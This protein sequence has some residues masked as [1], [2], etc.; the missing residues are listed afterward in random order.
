MSDKIFEATHLFFDKAP[1]EQFPEHEA[2]S[3]MTCSENRWWYI[4]HVITLEVGA[5]I[6]SDFQRITRIK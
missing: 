6:D 3:W 1:P 5:H 4:R 2:P